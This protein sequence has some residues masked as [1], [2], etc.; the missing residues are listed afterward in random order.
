MFNPVYVRNPQSGL[1]EAKEFADANLSALRIQDEVAT[2]LVQGYTNMEVIGDR[3]LTPVKMNKEVFRIPA[4]GEEVFVVSGAADMKRA[5]G[6]RVARMNTSNG[7]VAGELYEYA[8]GATV[9]NRERNEWG[10]NPN[11]LVNG[12]ILQVNERIKLYRE[13]LQAVACTTTTNYASGYYTSGAAFA[14]AT[15][16]DAV[17]KMMDLIDDVTKSI[18][19]RP[20]VVWFSPAAWRLWIRNA[21]VLA[22]LQAGGTPATPAT[23]TKEATAKILEVG[24]C[25]VGYSIYGYGVSAGKFKGTAMTKA[26]LWDS[27]QSSNAGVLYRGNGTGTEPAFGYT[28][29]RNNSPYVESYYENQTKSQVWDVEHFFNPAITKNT[30]GALYYSIA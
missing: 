20:N 19:R 30:A 15:T 12:R 8:L 2:G 13:Y 6:A 29:E 22:T 18:G 11:D 10:G 21:A 16:G 28:Y 3:L 14:W 24:E 23:V 5:V 27:V 25:L 1:L 7:Y 9:E 17:L 4:W 26:Y